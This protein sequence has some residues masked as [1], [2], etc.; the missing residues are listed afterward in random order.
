MLNGYPTEYA[1]ILSITNNYIIKKGIE[2]LKTA[3]ENPDVLKNNFVNKDEVENLIN[4]GIKMEGL[5]NP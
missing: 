5:E 1:G 3:I 2:Q 4:K